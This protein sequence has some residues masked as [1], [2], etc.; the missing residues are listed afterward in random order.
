MIR[1]LEIDVP[2]FINNWLPVH[3]RL[4]NRLSFL[5]VVLAPFTIMMAEYK[6]WRD[7]SITRAYVSGQKISMEWYL[8]ELFDPTNRD[9]YIDSPDNTG[10]LVALI[11][12]GAPA[13]TVGLQSEPTEV[14]DFVMVPL[15]Y[16]DVATGN[17]DFVVYVPIAYI[18]EEPAIRMVVLNYKLAG[19]RF[20]VSY[21]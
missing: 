16:E 10:T 19:K 14:G 20:V 8:N 5:Q 1:Q 7:K 4:V 6:A 9:I 13:L 17:A 21:F 15:P 11:A 18:A 2:N 3:Q 12:E